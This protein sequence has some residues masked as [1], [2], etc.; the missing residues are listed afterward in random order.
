MANLKFLLNS[1]PFYE[2]SAKDLL[3]YQKAK[4]GGQKRAR[5]PEF[6]SEY[7]EHLAELYERHL[8]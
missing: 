3:A 2:M 1:G 8:N 7:S 5:L 4:R 6:P